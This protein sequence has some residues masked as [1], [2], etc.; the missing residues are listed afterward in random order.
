MAIVLTSAELDQV[1]A[2]CACEHCERPVHADECCLLD[3]LLAIRADLA[4]RGV[5][6]DPSLLACIDAEGW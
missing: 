5:A 4:A 3:V 1:A 6:I 2:A